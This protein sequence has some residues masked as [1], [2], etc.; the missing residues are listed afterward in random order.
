MLNTGFKYVF[1]FVILV[2]LQ[3]LVFNNI[4][5]GGY[6]NPQIYVFFILMLPFSL[7][8]YILL[9]SAFTIGIVIDFFSDSTA[10]HTSASVFMAFCRPGVVRLLTGYFKPEGIETPG[11][12]NLGTFSLIIYNTILI[13]LHHTSLFF[14]EIFRFNEFSLT[15][16]RSL[17]SSGLTLIFVLLAFS[18]LENSTTKKH[19]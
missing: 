5:I 3:V 15:I 1:S 2:L 13:F 11:Y 10:I 8:G 12:Y 16:T 4:R 7:K 6:A 17:T 14:L 18:F 9:I 19:H